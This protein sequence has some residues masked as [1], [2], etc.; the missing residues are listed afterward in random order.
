MIDRNPSTETTRLRALGIAL[1]LVAPLVGCG[2]K[3]DPLPPLST[4]PAAATELEVQQ[5]GA[6]LIFDQEYP[7]STVSGTI[8]SGLSAL[9]VLDYP[10]PDG[11]T[12]ESVQPSAF[13]RGARVL[14]RITGA[15]LS[16]SIEG[17]RIRNR[18]GL[19]EAA[20]DDALHLLGTRT[21]ST[22]GEASPISNRV[23]LRLSEPPAP[24]GSLTVESTAAGVV[25]EW[26]SV[27][28]E[29]ADA[30]DAD[31][32]ETTGFHVYRKGASQRSYG[33]PLVRVDPAT[34]SFTDG[35]AV[36]GQRYFYTVRT[37]SSAEPLIESEAAVESEID[38]RDVFAPAPPAAVTALG[39]EQR[40]R[41]LLE[42][43]PADD[44]TGYVFFRR[45]PGADGFRRLNDQPVVEL[46]YVDTGL[47]TGLTYAYQVAA[48]DRAGNQGEASEPVTVEV[49]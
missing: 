26:T 49:R 21:F 22:E 38:H 18:V 8:L 12:A 19:E 37:V 25:V 1:M 28:P 3:G 39:E 34:R 4:A 13:E 15:E 9:E 20:R 17:N 11:A 7:Q 10:L 5:Q 30:P 6:V 2:K 16:S 23:T 24:P 47:A 46:E 31:E 27:T 45:E 14:V 44:V 48:V 36:F 29:V 43:S 42:P 32:I 40:V 41:L 33:E 35:T